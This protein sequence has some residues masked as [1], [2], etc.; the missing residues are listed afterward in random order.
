MIIILAIAA[1]NYLKSN[2][3]WSAWL[4]KKNSKRLKHH[5]NLWR[6]RRRNG[7]DF[8]HQARNFLTINPSSLN[9]LKHMREDYTLCTMLLG[10][11]KKS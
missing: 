9:N 7:P 5:I 6:F 8:S 3:L 4:L 11:M 2:N 10:L 1:K